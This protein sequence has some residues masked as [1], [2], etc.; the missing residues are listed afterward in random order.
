MIITRI[1]LLNNSSNSITFSL[2]FRF[3]KMDISTGLIFF[4]GFV[5]SAI[6]I[7]VIL[8]M[9]AKEKTYEEAIAE[10]RKIPDEQLLLGRNNKEKEKVKEKKSKKAGKKVKE[11]SENDKSENEKAHVNFEK[12]EAELL[13]TPP[14]QVNPFYFFKS[15]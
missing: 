13:T 11:K 1:V 7:Y 4:G 8:V 10:Q 9:G 3:V 5:I 6:F 2:I 14:N 15:I 12:P